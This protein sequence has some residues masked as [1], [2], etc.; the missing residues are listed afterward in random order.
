MVVDCRTLPRVLAVIACLA[1]VACQPEQPPAEEPPHKVEGTTIIFPAGSHKADD[2]RTRDLALRPAPLTRL[3]GRLAWNEDVTVRVYTPYGGR[4][5]RILVQPGATVKKGQPLAVIASPDFG[6]TQAEARRA[7]ADHALAEKNLARLRE[8]ADN[9]VASRKD[10]QTAETDLARART[11]LE[12]TERRLALHG[13]RREAVDQ[14]Y[15]LASPIAGIVVE[16]NINPG[17][18]LRPDQNAPGAPPLF[19]VTDPTQLWAIIDAAE[20]DLPRL[21][22]GRA[23]TVNTPAYRD[24]HF[25]ARITAISDFLDPATRSVK[26]RASLNNTGRRLKADMFVTA[27]VESDHER[28]LLVPTKAVYFQEGKNYAFVLEGD[29][30]YARREVQLDDVYGDE[31]EVI[32]GLNAGEKVVTQGALMLQQIL[33]PRR[34]MK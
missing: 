21:Q 27:E 29:G 33:K 17:Q 24:E 15:T 1:L 19:V 5:E 25:R 20:R 8:L 3:N 7:A 26:V 11:E 12:R 6:Q 32:E 34:V 9:G 23:I 4:V 18:E 14:T 31:V 2:I 16:R 22:V 28:V 30:R 13:G 10:L